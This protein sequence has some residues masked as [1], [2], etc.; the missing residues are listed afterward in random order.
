MTTGRYSLPAILL[1][2]EGL[3]ALVTSVVLYAYHDGSWLLF[4][5]L[6]LAPDLSALGY[7]AGAT[8]GAT[9]YDIVHTYTLP[10]ILGGIGYVTERDLA[11]SIALIWI[12]HIGTDR[13]IGYGL[14]Y[15]TDFKDTHLSRV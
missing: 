3:A 14:K 13:A 10:I 7:M 9:A 1:R 6:L 15:P 5:V 11:V 4:L 12:A 2:G 8:V